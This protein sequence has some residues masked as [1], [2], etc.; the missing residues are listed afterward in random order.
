M[1][2]P[3]WD[4]SIKGDFL[5]QSV[6]FVE[7]EKLNN[8]ETIKQVVQE[9]LSCSAHHMDHVMRV[10]R[11]S[12]HLA[13]DIPDVDLDILRP[14]VLLHDI[15]RVKE[16]R[17]TS[18][19]IDHA[20]LGAEMAENILEDLHYSQEDISN[21]KHCIRT[22]RFR[23]KKEPKSIEAKLLFDADK[24]DV[25]GAVGIA[26]SFMIAGQ[27]GEQMYTDV[28]INDY[29]KDNLV[30]GQKTGRIKDISKHTPNLEF[31]TKFKKI[32][33]KLHTKKA[34]TM[35]RERLKF[36]RLFFHRLKREINGAV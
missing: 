7:D 21:I 23:S 20:V 27:Y 30:G 29:V 25:L 1:L 8:L 32:P 12:L 10:Y 14:A 19:T 3:S 6:R 31:E 5:Y 28:N 13:K 36:M 33:E 26:R 4:I 17:D 9:E 35:A 24:V 18:G 11:L 15:A 16:D 2:V 22:H 34:K